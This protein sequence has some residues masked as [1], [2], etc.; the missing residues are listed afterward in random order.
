MKIYFIFFLLA[1]C[2]VSHSQYLENSPFAVAGAGMNLSRQPVLSFGA[3]YNFSRFYTAGNIT[4]TGERNIPALM[5]ARA[6]YILGMNSFVV[7]YTG[8]AYQPGLRF[9]SEESKGEITTQHSKSG[10]CYGMFITVPSRWDHM[11]IVFGGQMANFGN[12]DISS[13]AFIG[14]KARLSK[15]SPCD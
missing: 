2:M 9:S 13:S 3:G 5:E 4:V 1:V 11:S 8:F 10:Q 15:G 14:L 6:G 7:I 12:N